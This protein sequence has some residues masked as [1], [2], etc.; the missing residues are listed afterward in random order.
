M[1]RPNDGNLHRLGQ[2]AP[3]VYETDHAPIIEEWVAL[4]LMRMKGSR[5]IGDEIYTR[6]AAI[7]IAHRL[8]EHCDAVLPIEGASTGAD[9]DVRRARAKCIQQQ[10][11]AFIDL[12]IGTAG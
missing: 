12:D 8:L 7:R 9:E 6:C 5:T 1:H 4:P 11:H 10:H 3:V 2:A